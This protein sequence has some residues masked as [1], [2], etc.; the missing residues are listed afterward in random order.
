[1]FRIYL[2]RMDMVKRVLLTTV[3]LLTLCATAFSSILIDRV[4]AVIGRDVIT[5][6]ELYK[7]MEFQY[8]DKIKGMTPEERRKFLKQYEADFLDRLIDMKVQLKEAKKLNI[9]ATKKEVDRAIEQIR[10]KYGMTPEEFE[11]AVRKQGLSMEDYRK[12]L[13][14][15]ITLNKIQSYKLSTEVYVD[16]KE[17]EEYIRQHPEEFKKAE[18]Y[19]FRQILL[20]VR[21]DDEK[22]LAEDIA[23]KIMQMLRR[24]EPFDK[25]ADGFI[26]A[27]DA[28]TGK[29]A[30][31]I[32]RKE[33]AREFVNVLDHL[34]P[35]QFSRPFWTNRGLVILYLEEKIDSSGSVR[36]MAREKIRME[37]LNKKLKE[38]IRS[39]RS[40]YFIEV[41]L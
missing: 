10:K 8:A 5:W 19:R 4:V 18:G 25:V 35:G 16:D 24:G 31:F 33:L 6:S 9:S 23:S 14:E 11:A 36:D 27:P 32:S 2:K 7:A 29:E 26:K 39:L 12:K 40:K 38:W 17:V 1:M 21:N 20:R 34:H 30:I 13:A 37:K 3:V 28:F 22:R 15:Q 41:K